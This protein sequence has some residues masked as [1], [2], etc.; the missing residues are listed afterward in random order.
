MLTTVAGG[1]LMALDHLRAYVSAVTPF[2]IADYS[3]F[4]GPSNGPSFLAREMLALI[5]R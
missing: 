2:N 3:V 1:R 5:G 4:V